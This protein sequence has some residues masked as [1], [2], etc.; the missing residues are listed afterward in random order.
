MSKTLAKLGNTYADNAE[1][2][3]QLGMQPHKKER[4]G[5]QGDK[6]CKEK[7]RTLD[8]RKKTAKTRRQN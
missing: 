7:E 1:K 4:T 8:A 3:N 5:D 2:R 6:K